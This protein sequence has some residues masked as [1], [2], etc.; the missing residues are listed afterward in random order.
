[1]P[2]K[3]TKS[4][5]KKSSGVLISPSLLSADPLAFGKDAAEMEM[6][7]ADWHHIDVMDGHF[8]PNLTFGLPLIRA[9]K[10]VSKIPLDVHIMVSNPDD[11][12]LDYVSAG[13]DFL[14]FHAEAARH[15]HRLAQSIRSAGA[16]SG[17]SI[18]PG[19]SLELV[20]P[21]LENVDMVLIMSVNP[22]FG[23]QSFI[24]E[25]VERVRRLREEIE[26][27]GLGDNITISVDGGINDVTG[28]LV[29]AAGA[30][31]VVAGNFL[32][33]ALNRKKA[34]SSLKASLKV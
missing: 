18:N 10:K 30:G 14:T 9:L 17:I 16:K 32:Y 28:A 34:I 20:Y 7:G 5:S 11:T 19:S 6:L 29:A 1:M 12:A 2:S 8:V 33:G 13:A 15:P 24:R 22:G 27:R 26:R 23:G 31:A 25:S 4:K 21:L 3:L